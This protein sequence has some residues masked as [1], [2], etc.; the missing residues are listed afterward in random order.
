MEYISL[1]CINREIY[2]L[3]TGTAGML[4]HICG[5]FTIEQLYYYPDRNHKDLHLEVDSDGRLRTKLYDKRDDFNIPIVNFRFIRSTFPAATYE[6]YIS[7]MIGYS[8][9][10]DCGDIRCFRRVCR[11]CST[12]G[13]RRVNLVTTPIISR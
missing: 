4:L 8:R 6:V 11:L 7:Q 1:G 5:K 3:Y 9:A 10:C 13:T 2:T 12:S